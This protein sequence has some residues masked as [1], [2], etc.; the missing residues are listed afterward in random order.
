[1]QPPAY[2]N[3]DLCFA[4]TWVV[5]EQDGDSE[6]ED[7]LLTNTLEFTP[8]PSNIICD[9]SFEFQKNWQPLP[10]VIQ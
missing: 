2:D 5:M 8:F 6:K 1:M 4:H 7:S 3:C 10:H 9:F